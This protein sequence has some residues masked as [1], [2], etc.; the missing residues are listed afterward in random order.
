MK[1]NHQL[2]LTSLA[3]QSERTAIEAEI[4]QLNKQMKGYLKELGYVA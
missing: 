1:A 3:A 4:A 2:Q